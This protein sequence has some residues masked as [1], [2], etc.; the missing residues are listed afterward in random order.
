MVALNSSRVH[1][2]KEIRLQFAKGVAER[3][4]G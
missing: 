4:A 2:E 1:Q 3:L